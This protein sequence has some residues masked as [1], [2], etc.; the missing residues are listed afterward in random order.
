MDILAEAHDFL[1]RMQMLYSVIL[2][3]YGAY[4]YVQK[5]ALSGN[6]FGSVAVYAILNVIVL[7]LGIILNVSG[8]TILSEDRIFIYYLYML[9]LIVI[10]PGL[11]SMLRG[12]DDIQAAMYFF[13]LAFFN[14]AVSW[15]MFGR[16][17][18]S[19]VVA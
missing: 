7:I 9:F 8:Y 19:W 4:L 3:I 14:A 5:E 10:M 17:L 15:S 12:R 1:F 6:Y 11:F 2:G 13:I 16:G 18:A